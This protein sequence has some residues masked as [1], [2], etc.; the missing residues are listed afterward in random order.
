[1]NIDLDLHHTIPETEAKEASNRRHRCGFYRPGRTTRRLSK[2]VLQRR[3]NRVTLFRSAQEV[4][5]VRGILKV[6]EIDEELL[7]DPFISILDIAIPL[8]QQLGVVKAAVRHTDHIKGI[9]CQNPL[10]TS[11]GKPA[12][13]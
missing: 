12:R 7:A 9:L 1:M 6:Y 5:A 4:A 13:S 8:D 3:G 2:N 11:Y 10:S